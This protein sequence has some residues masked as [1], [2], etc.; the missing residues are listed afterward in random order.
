MITDEHV[1]GKEHLP[2][3]VSEVLLRKAQY[4]KPDPVHIED[5]NAYL[6]NIEREII[7]NTLRLYHNN[8]SKAAKHLKISRQN[9]Q[10]KIK[11]YNF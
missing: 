5:L 4:I 8:I 6:G 1:I 3:H 7:E 11:N 9:L 10:Y 2:S